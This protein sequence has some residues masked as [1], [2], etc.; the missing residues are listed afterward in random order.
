MYESKFGLIPLILF[1]KHVTIFNF[2][3]LSFTK[4]PVKS[5]PVQGKSILRDLRKWFRITKVLIAHNAW[6]ANKDRADSHPK[7]QESWVPC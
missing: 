7:L 2:I 1:C 6:S 4:Y 5:A 3:F